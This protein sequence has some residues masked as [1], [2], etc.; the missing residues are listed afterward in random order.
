MHASFRAFVGT[1]TL[2]NL[3][4]ALCSMLLAYLLCSI[5]AEIVCPLPGNQMKYHGYLF[6]ESVANE[7]S[8]VND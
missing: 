8:L 4:P 3:V 6:I 7:I 5:Y 2:Q 1:K